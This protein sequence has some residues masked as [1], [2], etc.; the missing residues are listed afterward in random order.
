MFVNHRHLNVQLKLLLNSKTHYTALLTIDNYRINGIVGVTVI[1][2]TTIIVT[3]WNLSTTLCILAD[4]M[5][6]LHCPYY[7]LSPQ[8]TPPY[9]TDNRLTMLGRASGTTPVSDIVR[10]VVRDSTSFP[11]N[12]VGFS[13]T[14]PST[15]CRWRLLAAA[16]AH[17]V[18]NVSV[19]A[20]WLS[21]MVSVNDVSSFT[22]STTSCD[23]AF[24]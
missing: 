12:S 15:D 13:T 17:S 19:V 20:G 21:D 14:K 16:A 18:S 4:S 2:V 8:P 10:C 23:A 24:C 7:S 11:G 6:I 22:K 9:V 3:I 1:T 5:Y